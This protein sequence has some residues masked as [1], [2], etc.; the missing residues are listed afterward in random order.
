[1]QVLAG[2]IGGTHSR[3][4]LAEVDGPSVKT[5]HEEHY[6]S[7]AFESLEEVLQLFLASID[8]PPARACFAVAG[9][10][11]GQH[12][13][14]T[15]LPWQVETSALQQRFAFDRVEL[16]N[17]FAAIGYSLP[18]LTRDDYLILQEGKAQPAATRLVLGA[19]TGLGVALVTECSGASKVLPSEGGHMDFA[20]RTRAECELANY[21]LQ[22]YPRL[23]YEHLL[24]GQGLINLYRYQLQCSGQS[25]ASDSLLQ[26]TDPAAAI[27]QAASAGTHPSALAA[28]AKFLELYGACAGNLALLGLALGGV[29][30]AGGIAAKLATQ[31][32]DSE[33]LTAFHAKSSMSDL[34]QEFPVKILVNQRVGLLGAACYASR[35]Q[36]G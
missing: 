29:Y 19:G 14:I 2:D 23:S 30:I 33:F 32:A 16:L 5:L 13:Q 4:L 8:S 26:Q 18:V 7:Q 25:A 12:A 31:F 11:Q 28:L 20:P 34:M 22:S 10:V 3:L 6:A 9:P 36:S 1:M 27:S 21:L 17:D 15:N 24:S 35:L